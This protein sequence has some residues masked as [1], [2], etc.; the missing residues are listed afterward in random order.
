ML[1]LKDIPNLISYDNISLAISM[2]YLGESL[3]NMFLL[4]YDWEEQIRMLFVNLT[5]N[6]VYYPE[7]NLNNIV[8]LN[9]KISFIDFGLAQISDNVDNT[10][11]CNVFIKLLNLLNDKYKNVILTTHR[12]IIYNTLINTI[13]NNN[14]YPLNVF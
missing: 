11:N 9:N 2:N 7:F 4:P 14:M 12:H 6:N 3:Y 10:N 8:V 5:N 13:K 1:K